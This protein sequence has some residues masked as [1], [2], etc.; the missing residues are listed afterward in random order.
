MG[1]TRLV[2]AREL[3]TGEFDNDAVILDLRDGVYYGLD[4]AGASTWSLLQRPVT[5]LALRDAM[6]A[7]YDVEPARC[8]TDLKELCAELLRRGLIR[9]ADD[10]DAP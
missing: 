4:G 5:V 3:L 9:V 6:V 8:L 1:S 7:E 10:H 2:A